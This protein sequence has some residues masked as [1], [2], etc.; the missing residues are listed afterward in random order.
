MQ[1][2]HD[3]AA[4]GIGATAVMDL[5][6]VLLKYAG[7]PM[8]SFAPIGRWV[9]HLLRGRF[10]HASIAQ[11]RPIAGEVALG[12]A[13]HY[14]VGIAFAGLLFALQGRAWVLAP[15]FWPALGLGAATVAAPWLVMQ[16]AMGAGIAARKTPAPLTNRV[17]SLA[18]HCVFG[19][20][21]YLSAAALRTVAAL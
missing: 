7:V 8:Q 4:I 10:A 5:W 9:G 19:A 1:P 14:A 15:T 20:G 12:W 6:L 21:L 13:T 2:V 17:R 18:N 3:L 16:P 11:A